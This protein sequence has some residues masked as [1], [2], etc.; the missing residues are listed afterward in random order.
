MQNPYGLYGFVWY[1]FFDENGIPVERSV[2]SKQPSRKNIFSMLQGNRNEQLPVSYQ[3]QV[4]FE[5]GRD[6]NEA[7][8]DRNRKLFFEIF[9]RV[10]QASE[11]P[12]QKAKQVR[13]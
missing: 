13:N 2:A 8:L 5:S 7:E 3:V 4:V 10:R 6:L 11:T 9:E 12:L 1:G